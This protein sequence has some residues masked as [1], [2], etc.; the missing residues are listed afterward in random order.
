MKNAFR[1]AP[2]LIVL[3]S[4]LRLTSA[5]E[6]GAAK[7]IRFNRDIRPIL[8][9][10][11]FHCHGADPGSRKAKLRLDREDGF[12]GDRKDGPTVV[13]GKSATSPMYQHVTSDDP[14]EQMPPP[15]KTTHPLK[16]D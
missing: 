8:A 11:C 6:G 2:L 3:L 9:E 5:S 1:I 16:P 7:P 12:F 15:T 4:F 14:D 10:N 13:R